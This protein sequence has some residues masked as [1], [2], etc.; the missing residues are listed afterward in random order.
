MRLAQMYFQQEKT[1]EALPI[2]K[3]AQDIGKEILP[4]DHVFHLVVARS[5][6]QHR[7][8]EG[9]CP[10]C[11]VN[12]PGERK[13]RKPEI[14]Q[15]ITSEAEI[16]FPDAPDVLGEDDEEDELKPESHGEQDELQTMAT[17]KEEDVTFSSIIT[18]VNYED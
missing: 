16:N 10:D 9:C 1:D 15:F 7:I 3:E 14:H 8:S 2:L 12:P 6:A 13:D 11:H 5:I 18:T 4:D 17:A